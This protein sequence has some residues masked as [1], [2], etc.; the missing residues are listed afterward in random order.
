MKTTLLF[1]T[2]CLLSACAGPTNGGDP[3]ANSL[4]GGLAL[5]DACTASSVCGPG[6]ECRQGACQTVA[7]TTPATGQH[8]GDDADGG[9]DGEHG[10]HHS[11]GGA[12]DGDHGGGDHHDGGIDDDGD[13]ADGGDGDDHAGSGLACVTDADCL[14][15]ERCHHAV[16]E[17]H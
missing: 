6:L 8:D 2:L 12:D 16:C 1:S 11:D 13:H 14:V 4:N 5:G 17:A 9:E 10:G 15:G 7:A 3:G